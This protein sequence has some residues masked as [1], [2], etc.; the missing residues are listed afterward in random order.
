MTSGVFGYELATGWAKLPPDWIL[1]QTGVATDSSD[2]VYLFNTGTHPM[3]VLD[4]DGNYLRS[5]GESF[6][7]D[8][9]GIFLDGNDAL[10]LPVRRQHV[11]LKCD[12]YG[13]V[14][15]TLGHRDVPSDTG[16]SGNWR[17]VLE[18]CAGPF[19][20]PTDAGVTASGDIY[21]A[22]GYGNAR[23]HRFDSS[24]A[25]LQSWGRPGKEA[26]AEFHLPHGVWAHPDGRVFVADRENNRVQIFTDAGN[27]LEVW[28]GLARPCDIFID[29]AGI[30]YVAELDSLISI[31]GPDGGLLARWG[32]PTNSTGMDGG[33]QIWVDSVGDIYVGQNQ[34][35]SRILK[36]RRI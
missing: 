20:A 7:P 34:K 33:H 22:D 15:M 16:Y 21:V 6:L 3:I 9:H 5:W 14:L 25:L 19:N 28:E 18:R 30:V 4:P 31:F 11:V 32:S 23:I 1:G 10:Y 8:A 17:S 26:P 27:F 12:L 24:G 13:R 2:N 35:A 29:R 36:Y